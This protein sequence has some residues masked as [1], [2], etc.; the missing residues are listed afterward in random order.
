MYLVVFMLYEVYGNFE[1]ELRN[2]GLLAHAGRAGPGRSGDMK[3]VTGRVGP[4]H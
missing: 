3:C 2:H 4:D 1:V